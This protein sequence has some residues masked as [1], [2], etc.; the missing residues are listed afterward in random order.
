MHTLLRIIIEPDP[1]PSLTVDARDL[2]AATQVFDGLRPLA[3]CYPIGNAAAVSSAVKTEH[4]SRLCR[5]PAM[6]KRID[7]K[8]AMRS[9]QARI[10]SFEKIEPGPPHQ[11][12]VG[13]DPQVIVAL[14]EA[15]IHRDGGQPA[16]DV[17]LTGRRFR[18]NPRAA[19]A[20]RP[21]SPGFEVR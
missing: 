11:R 21:Y 17:R 3:R 12:P 7:A 14:I 8:R 9:D 20:E 6:H 19:G 18:C 16:A 15:C 1:P 13:E 4:Q 2:F 10:S 5:R